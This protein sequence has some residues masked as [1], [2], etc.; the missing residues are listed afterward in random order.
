MWI[1]GSLFD[2]WYSKITVTS[3]CSITELAVVSLL[4]RQFTFTSQLAVTTASNAQKDPKVSAATQKPIFVFP[5]QL[6]L[7]FRIVLMLLIGRT[8]LWRDT[9]NYKGSHISMT[10]AAIR[11]ANLQQRTVT[12]RS[13]RLRYYHVT[14]QSNKSLLKM[15]VFKRSAQ[16]SDWAGNDWCP[17]VLCNQHKLLL[18]THM[19]ARIIPNSYYNEVFAGVISNTETFNLTAI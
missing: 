1:T 4:K 13:P 2:N 14:E 17:P 12:G 11:V 15:H 18:L 8:A 9:D 5:V 7:F 3:S 16:T 10:S 19:M 6:Y